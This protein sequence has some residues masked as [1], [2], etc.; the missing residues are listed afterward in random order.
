MIVLRKPNELRT[1]RK[2]FLWNMIGSTL[3]GF[4]SLFLLIIITRING[5]S[6]AGI[7]S[8]SFSIAC[9]MFIIGGYSGRVYQVTDVNNTYS[10]LEYIYH[11]LI[12]CLIMMLFS[13]IYCI[14][15]E[16][17]SYKFLITI[18]LCFM[19]A[20]EAFSDSFLAILQKNNKLY[21]S[22][23]SMSLKSFFSIFLFLIIDLIFSDLLISIIV[24]ILVWLIIVILFDFR[25]TFKYLK[26]ES[27]IKKENLLK[28]FKT[29]F[30]PFAVLFLTIYLSNAP[31]YALDGMVSESSQAIFGI[32]IMPA[33]LVSLCVQYILQ[34]FLNKISTF[35]KENNKNAYKKLINKLLLWTL[36]IGLAILLASIIFGIPVLSMIYSVRL[37]K[38]YFEF[39]LIMIGAI[40]FSL[41][42]LIATA[43]TTIRKIKIQLIVFLFTSFITL[44]ISRP[45]ILT[46]EI[47]G[48]SI[49]YFVSTL[50]LTILYFI[51]YIFI[52]KR[53]DFTETREG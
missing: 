47:T 42:S 2:D 37:D 20:L 5:L 10:D 51:S 13:F 34:P 7:F 15:M 27:K 3:N 32:I 38:F 22:G 53:I 49:L 29:G 35:Y 48:A 9:L 50:V 33:T 6:D 26:F 17:S 44:I 40:F 45:L 12:T 14:V 24:L 43:L 18:L 39:L 36:L 25:K 16:Y 28:L 46:L 1:F 23:I 41:T 31:K 8:L 19:K 4:I 21:L 52:I 11:K 30:Y